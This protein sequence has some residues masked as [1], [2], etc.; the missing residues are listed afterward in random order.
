VKNVNPSKLTRLNIKDIPYLNTKELLTKYIKR[1]LSIAQIYHLDISEKIS[2]RL[3]LEIMDLLPELNTLKMNSIT[4]GES[5]SDEERYMMC[6]ILNRSQ[7]TKVYLQ[8]I[9]YIKEVF[10]LMMLCPRIVYIEINYVD[11]IDIEFILRCIFEEDLQEF[12]DQLR[13]IC[14]RIL[15]ADNNMIQKLQKMINDEKLLTDYS[16][17]RVIDKIYLQWK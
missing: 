9:E 3:L 14:F 6:L 16:I 15:A 13:S 5:L 12:S 4:L 11:Q 2:F 10:I 1:I 7:I 8:E 17:E